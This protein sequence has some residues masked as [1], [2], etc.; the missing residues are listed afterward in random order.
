MKRHRIR[1][2]AF[3][4]ALAAGG[5]GAGVRSAAAVPFNAGDVFAA[6]NDGNVQHYDASGT[7]LE[8]L[9]TGQ[10]GATGG[11]TF[12]AVG[13]LYVTNFAANSITEFAGRLGPHTAT[14]FGP[15]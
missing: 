14:L 10:G 12:D 1:V 13:N 4:V 15:S 3:T 7:L 8:T 11:C 5:I 9:N 2:L 6:V